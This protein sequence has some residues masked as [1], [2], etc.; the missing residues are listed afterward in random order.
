M[1]LPR[2]LPTRNV[3]SGNHLEYDFLYN[4]TCIMYIEYDALRTYLKTTTTVEELKSKSTFVAESPF[5][6]TYKFINIWVGETGGGL[7]PSLKNGL[8]GFK[9]EKKWINNNSVNESLINLQH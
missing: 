5:G 7:P 3:I 4:S 9:V 6:K 8:I 2:S 1:S